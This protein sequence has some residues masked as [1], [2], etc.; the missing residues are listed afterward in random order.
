MSRDDP[1]I[2]DLLAQPNWHEERKALR[3]IVLGCGLVETVKWAKLCYTWD[4]GNVAII[5]GMK[6]YCGLGF[7]KGALLK[8]AEG[9]LVPPG[10]HS[11]AM[12]LIH[13]TSVSEIAALRG[14]IETYVREAVEIE[15]S[16]RQVEFAEKD[17]LVY[18]DELE[19]AFDADPDLR[20]AFEALTPGRQRG[21]VLHFSG[22]KKPETRE[23][24]IRKAAPDILAGK[25]MHDR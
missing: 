11:Q 14:V 10:E 13:A 19:A 9:L 4:G 22:A 15:K 6:D 2:N 24:R 23:S 17:R 16:G 7:F 18:P 12:R 25:G 3:D 5:Y 1:K 8:D 20:A 21:Y